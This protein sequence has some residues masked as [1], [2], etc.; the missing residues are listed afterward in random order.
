VGWRAGGR[1]GGWFKYR[2]GLH[3][4]QIQTWNSWIHVIVV[5]IVNYEPC[6]FVMLSPTGGRVIFVTHTDDFRVVGDNMADV[7][8]VTYRFHAKFQITHVTTGVMLRCW[9]LK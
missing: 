8:Y 5:A 7:D 2:L 9:G 6:M 1:A 4:L 3:A